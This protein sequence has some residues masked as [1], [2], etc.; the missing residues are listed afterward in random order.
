MFVLW[1]WRWDLGFKIKVSWTANIVPAPAPALHY[2]ERKCIVTKYSTYCF[3]F[4]QFKVF[5][6]L[7]LNV[8][9]NTRLTSVEGWGEG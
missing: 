7:N 6:I 5:F 8:N 2:L 9:E 1:R 4:V 3:R